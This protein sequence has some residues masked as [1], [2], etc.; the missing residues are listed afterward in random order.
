[1]GETGKRNKLYM[2]SNDV[3]RKLLTNCKGGRKLYGRE[4]WQTFRK[5]PAPGRAQTDV[6]CAWP[7]GEK[8]TH[9]LRGTRAR[10]A[11]PG[12]DRDKY[13]T[14]PNW[15]TDYRM[16]GPESSQSLKGTEVTERLKNGSRLKGTRDDEKRTR[17][18]L[19]DGAA[20]CRRTS[21]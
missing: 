20:H 9:H 17:L 19:L 14:T 15:E 3:L 4:S 21:S 1:M 13:R 6:K 2:V 11:C 10:R 5:S 8:N 18:V 12:S 16:T 7:R